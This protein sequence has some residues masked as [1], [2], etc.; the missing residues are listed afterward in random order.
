MIESTQIIGNNQ[1]KQALQLYNNA[2]EQLV[3]SISFVHMFVD[4]TSVNVSA[5]WTGT[6]ESATTC[7]GALGDG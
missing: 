2:S 5:E 4:M 7:L 3:G 1:F 6:G